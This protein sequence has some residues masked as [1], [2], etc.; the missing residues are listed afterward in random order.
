VSDGRDVTPEEL[1]RTLIALMLTQYPMA[2]GA[3]RRAAVEH[4]RIS[5]ALAKSLV[6]EISARM[7]TMSDSGPSQ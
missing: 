2:T 4:C 3:A 1:A 6:R 5:P 7:V